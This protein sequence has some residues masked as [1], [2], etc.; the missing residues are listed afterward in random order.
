MVYSF[1]SS[2]L[3]SYVHVCH[4]DHLHNYLFVFVCN[5]SS[6]LEILECLMESADQLSAD[7]C[8]TAILNWEKKRTFQKTG[9]HNTKKPSLKL[10]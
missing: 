10:T 4:V 3:L 9:T 8:I 5:L 7:P 2:E 6:I 1:L